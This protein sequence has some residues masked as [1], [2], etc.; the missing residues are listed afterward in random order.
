MA[1]P[2]LAP[3]T[4]SERPTA[5]G[6]NPEHSPDTKKEIRGTAATPRSLPLLVQLKGNS[7]PSERFHVPTPAA[8]I[9]LA[10]G[11]FEEYVNPNTFA[12]SSLTPL[13]WAVSSDDM[14]RPD[15]H[16]ICD[17]CV[18]IVGR[19][20]FTS[21]T[22]TAY[23]QVFSCV[24]HSNV[25]PPKHIAEAYKESWQRFSGNSARQPYYGKK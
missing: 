13:R 18:S 12:S 8:R 4:R 19:T 9:I 3:N 22:G 1:S 7:K 5:T 25:R 2:G 16:A 11:V 17:K 23:K 21:P 6:L 10:M 15:I 14:G 20:I 24:H